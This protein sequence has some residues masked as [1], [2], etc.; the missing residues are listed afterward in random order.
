MFAKIL[1][2]VVRSGSLRLIDGAGRIHAIGDDSPPRVTV[3]LRSRR[4]DITLALNPSLSIGEAYMDGMFVIEQGTL[5]DFL[6]VI[7]RNA[8]RIGTHPWLGLLARLGTHI[9]QR[10]PIGRARRNVAHHY[11]LSDKLYDIFLDRDRQYSC[12]Y[13]TSETDS[14]ETAQQNKKRHIASK[15]MLDQPGLR[16]LDIG[17]GWGGL[18]LYLAQTAGAD[19]TG[20]TLSTEQHKMSTARVAEAGLTDQVRFALRDYREQE[21]TFDRIVSVGM[22]EHVGKKNYAEFF[23]R[24]RDLL[25]DDGVALL[26]AIGDNGVPGPI[27]PFI[28]KYIFPGADTPSLSEVFSAV[29]R[30]GLIVTDLEIL[31]LHYART[32]RLWRERFMA[33]RDEVAALYDERFCRMWEFYLALCEVGF[34]HRSNIVFQMQLAKRRDVVPITRDTMGIWER[35]HAERPAQWPSAVQ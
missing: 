6:D 9:Q 10:N 16:I 24:L 2:Y 12:A 14:L 29:E 1:N 35:A 32:L 23:A 7:G 20:V 31:R 33:R 17:S 21:G 13:F 18:G 4:L 22:F 15:L 3:R 5:Y 26:H 34:R 25:V 11:D 8:D 19:V 30:S 28:R 27:N